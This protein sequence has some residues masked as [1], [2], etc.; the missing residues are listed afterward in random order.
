MFPSISFLNTYWDGN[1]IRN[2]TRYLRF[3]I[4]FNENI[5]PK[6]HG[7]EHEYYKVKQVLRLSLRPFK[8][9]LNGKWCLIFD[10]VKY[11]KTVEERNIT[12]M[13]FNEEFPRPLFPDEDAEKSYKSTHESSES[14]DDNKTWNLLPKNIQNKI[15]KVIRK[16]EVMIILTRK[17]LYKFKKEL[18]S[19]VNLDLNYD[20]L[21]KIIENIISPEQT[22]N[23]VNKLNFFLIS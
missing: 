19:L 1:V 15:I 9:H 5:I 4:E 10:G 3:H 12:S 23:K 14:L 20:I 7:S 8:C 21:E 18:I 16:Y 2:F 6:I 22:Y 11:I 13:K 17:D